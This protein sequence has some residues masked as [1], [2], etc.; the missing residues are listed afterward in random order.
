MFSQMGSGCYTHKGQV[1]G[2]PEA[3]KQIVRQRGPWKKIPACRIDRHFYGRTIQAFVH[4][5]SGAL[6]LHHKWRSRNAAFYNRAG[7]WVVAL[8]GVLI[9]RRC[10]YGCRPRA[11]PLRWAS[12]VLREFISGIHQSCHVIEGHRP[13]V[14]ES[15]TEKYVEHDELPESLFP[16]G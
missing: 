6:L 8:D 15:I 14:A 11:V 7:A 2:R 12:S 10:Y 9:R 4:V 1:G 13:T 16:R 5:R 3:D